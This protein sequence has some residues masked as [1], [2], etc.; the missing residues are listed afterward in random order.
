MFQCLSTTA[1]KLFDSNKEHFLCGDSFCY[2]DT[3][4]PSKVKGKLV[5]CKL[6]TWGTESVVKGIGGIGTLIESDQFPDVAQIFMAP[7]TIV[8]S[9]QGDNVTKYI[10][11][12][13]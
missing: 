11:S 1:E 6:G 13:R 3:L 7:A 5:Y 12:T 10:Q 4:Q 9:V 2:E 8:N